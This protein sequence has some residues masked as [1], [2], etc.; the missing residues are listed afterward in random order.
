M[1]N[2]TQYVRELLADS[3]IPY[4][5]SQPMGPA[6]GTAFN[7]GNGTEIYAHEDMPYTPA[8]LTLHEATPEHPIMAGTFKPV[9]KLELTRLLLRLTAKDNAMHF[10]NSPAAAADTF[11]LTFDTGNA[12]FHEEEHDE[13]AP[14]RNSAETARI[15]RELAGKVEDGSLSGT[16][17]DVNGNRIGGWSWH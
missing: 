5:E 6:N 11:A 3:N 14:A 9:S 15:L 12:A 7:I 8:H 17:L 16:I 13:E 1:S 4:T 2:I 10:R